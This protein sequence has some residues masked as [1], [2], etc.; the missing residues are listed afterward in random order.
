MNVSVHLCC[1]KKYLRRIIYEEQKLISHQLEARN[2]MIK[3][4]AGLVSGKGLL[5]VSKMAPCFWILQ[6]GGALCP[7]MLEGLQS[8][9]SLPSI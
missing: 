1:Y 8:Q 9:D 2:S 4:P 5:F 7:Y 3:V 6:K